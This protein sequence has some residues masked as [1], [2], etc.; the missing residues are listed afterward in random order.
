MCQ[1]KTIGYAFYSAKETLFYQKK[2]LLDVI[3]ILGVRIA[4]AKNDYNLING[5]LNAVKM[6]FLIKNRERKI[7]FD[8]LFVSSAKNSATRMWSGVTNRVQLDL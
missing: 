5:Y 2:G 3:R 1:I 6:R 7:T 4:R 8:S